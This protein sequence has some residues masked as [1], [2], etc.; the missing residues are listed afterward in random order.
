MVI[1]GNS[2]H[3]IYNSFTVTHE[4]FFVTTLYKDTNFERNNQTP[5]YNYYF[6]LFSQS[7]TKSNIFKCLVTV[8]RKFSESRSRFY[9]LRW[10]KRFFMN[11][12]YNYMFLGYS[13]FLCWNSHVSFTVILSENLWN[14]LNY[15]YCLST[16]FN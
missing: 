9:I 4:I 1:I 5:Y 10:I 12:S 7:F 16:Y 15:Y 8:T 2:I 6:Y 13:S 3:S 11:P 14:I